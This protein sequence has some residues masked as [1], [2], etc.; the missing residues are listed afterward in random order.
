MCNAATPAARE[1]RVPAAPL[2]N[3]FDHATCTSSVERVIRPRRAVVRVAGIDEPAFGEV[4]LA[5]RTDE[6]QQEGRR[7]LAGGAREFVDE[8]TDRKAVMNRVHAAIPADA[9]VRDGGADF[10]AH[11]RHVP[12][13]V[14]CAVR[15]LV[16]GGAGQV[17]CEGRADRWVR[18]A[19]QPGGDPA[20]VIQRSLEVVGSDGVIVRVTHVVLA[21]PLHAHRRAG[22]A[23]EECGL[24]DEV[25]LG[26]AAERA[27]QQRDVDRD[28]RRVDLEVLGNRVAR[29]VRGLRRSP[30]FDLA[31]LHACDRRQRLHLRVREI[32]NV[33]LGTH[34]ACRGRKCCR[35]IAVRAARRARRADAGLEH[36]FVGLR[37]MRTIRACV[38]GDPAA[39]RARGMPPRCSSR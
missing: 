20:R 17:R 7:V 14:A 37:V 6:F 39:H 4:H 23:R 13:H 25:R 19:M 2:L 22:L 35:D 32:R 21:A 5:V 31:I 11:V 1:R 33:V 18:R 27:A 10:D 36:R 30:G 29:I 3:G 12:R 26:L 9:R 8:R 38:P 28:V 15:K 24:A 16:R 34:L